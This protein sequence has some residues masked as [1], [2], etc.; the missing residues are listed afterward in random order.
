MTYTTRKITKRVIESVLKSHNIK[1]ATDIKNADMDK[2]RDSIIKKYNEVINVRNAVR[3]AAVDY[4]NIQIAIENLDKI[5]DDLEKEFAKVCKKLEMNNIS[6]DFINEQRIGSTL[7]FQLDKDMGMTNIRHD[8]VADILNEILELRFIDLTSNNDKSKA[9]LARYV[10]DVN[11]PEFGTYVT[12]DDSKYDT[13]LH[14]FIVKIEPLMNASDIDLIYRSLRSRVPFV[15]KQVNPNLIA[16]QNGVFDFKTK[17]LL[18]FSSDYI[19]LNKITTNFNANATKSPVIND[20]DDTWEFHQWINELACNDEG[21][22]NGLMQMLNASLRPAVDFDQAIFMIASKGNNGKGTLLRLITNLLGGT[23][24]CDIS[25]AGLEDRFGLDR[26]LK[27]SVILADENNVGDYIKGSSNFKRIVTHDN[28]TIERKNR[29]NINMKSSHFMIQCLND[30]PRLRDTTESN[31]RRIFPIPMNAKFTGKAK[32]YIKN[33]YLARPEVLEYILNYLLTQV[34][35]F[36]A[37]T[38]FEASN[39]LLSDYVEKNNPIVTFANEFLK[40]NSD[41]QPVWDILPAQFLTDLYTAWCKKVGVKA[42]G[43]NTFLSELN[44]I[45]EK[46]SDEFAFESQTKNQVRVGDKMDKPEYLIA[47]YRLVDWYNDDYNEHALSTNKTAVC[48]TTAKPKYRGFLRKE[49]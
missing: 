37:F 20:N 22:V 36:T 29:D 26:L 10:D 28:V 38:P 24:H 40:N 7:K 19:F 5:P 3:K 12:V 46:N 49:K 11:E 44:E 1:T 15:N 45:L 30:M 6:I 34:D 39:K 16:V 41:N 17:E 31:Y 35:D 13:V 32:K 47:E 25:L 9:V 18:P 33:D 48:R 4:V 21:V 43:R 23:N 8:M 14:E 42:V 2:I 27:S